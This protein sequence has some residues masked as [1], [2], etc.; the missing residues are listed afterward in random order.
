[1]FHSN[2]Y[3]ETIYISFGHEIIKCYRIYKDRE[4]FHATQHFQ[5]DMR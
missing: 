2:F 1:M 4:I 3:N 5:L